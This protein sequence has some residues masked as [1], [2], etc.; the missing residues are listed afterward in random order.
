MG[1]RCLAVVEIPLEAASECFVRLAR[2]DT[3]DPT[4]LFLGQADQLIGYTEPLLD[5]DGAI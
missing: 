3:I 4:V 1:V 2:P 5:R